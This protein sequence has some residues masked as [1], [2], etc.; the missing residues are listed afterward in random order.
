MI[1]YINRHP[2]FNYST[3]IIGDGFY[4]ELGEYVKSKDWLFWERQRQVRIVRES[5]FSRLD[6][7]VSHMKSIGADVFM[8]DERKDEWNG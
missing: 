2:D 3:A 1:V 8:R 5:G 6:E 7:F 4:P